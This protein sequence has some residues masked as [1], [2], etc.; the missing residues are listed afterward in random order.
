MSE[1]PTYESFG[2]ALQGEW[3]KSGLKGSS[4]Q[5]GKGAVEELQRQGVKHNRSTI[6]DWL[7]GKKTPPRSA[8]LALKKVFPSLPYETVEEVEAFYPGMEWGPE[9]DRNASPSERA[10]ELEEEI[11]R[12]HQQVRRSV[13]KAADS[14]LALLASLDK[15]HYLISSVTSIPMLI[16]DPNDQHKMIPGRVEAILKGARFVMIVPTEEYFRNRVSPYLRGSLSMEHTAFQRGYRKFRQNAIAYLRREHKE[17]DAEQVMSE[18]VQLIE[19]DYFPFTAVGWAVSLLGTSEETRE[20]ARRSYQV[21]MRGPYQEIFALQLWTREKEDFESGV[22]G[23]CAKVL[24][25]EMSKYSDEE[26]PLHKF[27]STLLTRMAG[28]HW[29]YCI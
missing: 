7:H 21:M 29:H 4:K 1:R 5:I 28:N 25:N 22:C 12:A 10:A 14:T 9:K 3:R 27:Y 20:G 18:G 26:D 15:R 17:K 23:W 6:L 2:A 19:C 24:M 8:F 11:R 13:E 16:W